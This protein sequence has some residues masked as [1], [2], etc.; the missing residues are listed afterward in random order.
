MKK[1]CETKKGELFACTN[2]FLLENLG[3]KLDLEGSK[4]LW[5]NCKIVVIRFCEANFFALY[6]VTVR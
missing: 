3:K 2:I 5:Y 4:L 6:V 1:V